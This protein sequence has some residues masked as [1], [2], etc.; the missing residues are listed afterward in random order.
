MSG[1]AQESSDSPRARLEAAIEAG[2]ALLDLMDG[3]PDNEPDLDAEW[4]DE[5]E[6]EDEDQGSWG[7]V[8]NQ[9]TWA[10]VSPGAKV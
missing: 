6:P 4:T 10:G 3:D 7:E 9:L 1:T 8:I 5:R 2:I